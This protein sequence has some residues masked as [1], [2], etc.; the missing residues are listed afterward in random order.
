MT[1]KALGK[2][3]SSL[4]PEGAGQ[5]IGPPP[6]VLAPE[7][8]ATHPTE[9]ELDRIDP[10]PL[11]PRQHFREAEL[12][13]LSASILRHGVVQPVLT[14]WMTEALS[15]RTKFITLIPDRTRSA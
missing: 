10:N 8:G 13:E 1:R 9:I 6:P 7:V 12:E 3:L 5:A 4:I 14:I 11:Q 2:G 15:G